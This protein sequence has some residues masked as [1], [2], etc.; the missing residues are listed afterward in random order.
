MPTVDKDL[1]EL[2]SPLKKTSPPSGQGGDDLKE[3]LSPL[4]SDVSPQPVPVS[5]DLAPLLAPLS[6]DTAPAPTPEPKQEM[7]ELLSPLRDPE[8][9][10]PAGND[11]PV[12]V[13]EP[14]APQPQPAPAAQA[15]VLAPQPA[16]PLRTIATPDGLVIG[17][18]NLKNF[19]LSNL[20]NADVAELT[21][22]IHDSNVNLLALQE[23]EG[24]AVMDAAMMPHF[25][26]WQYRMNDTPSQQ[27]LGFM[28]NPEMVD[29]R[30]DPLSYY[31]DEKLP[32]LDDT[33]LFSRPPMV[34]DFVDKKTGAPFRV[35]NVHLKSQFIPSGLSKEGR[36]EVKSRNDFLRQLQ[37]A[38]LN[39]LGNS[40]HADGT[41]V[42]IVGDYNQ[43]FL[44]NTPASK[45]A[46]KSLPGDLHHL[47]KGQKSFDKID[48]N[49]RNL[50]SN[51]DYLISMGMPFGSVGLPYEQE[52]ALARRQ[53]GTRESPDHDLV[54][55]VVRFAKN[56]GL[57][58]DVIKPD[59]SSTAVVNRDWDPGFRNNPYV[60]DA[61]QGERSAAEVFDDILPH[62]AGYKRNNSVTPYHNR[63][64][65]RDYAQSK[66]PAAIQELVYTPLA[67]LGHIARTGKD[68]PKPPFPEETKSGTGNAFTGFESGDLIP[69]ASS[70]MSNIA[71]TLAKGF[72][73][74]D[75]TASAI[76]KSLLETGIGK[77]PGMHKWTAY[78]PHTTPNPTIAWTP[79]E[80]QPMNVEDAEDLANWFSGPPPK[81]EAKDRNPEQELKDLLAL[82]PE[83]SGFNANPEFVPDSRG[84]LIK[85]E[86]VPEGDP[87]FKPLLPVL[88]DIAYST[89]GGFNDWLADTT[90]GLGVKL[91]GLTDWAGD[92][93]GLWNTDNTNFLQDSGRAIRN[94]ARLADREVG[95]KK[96]LTNQIARKFGGMIP[97]YAAMAAGGAGLLSP[98]S[99]PGTVVSYP[100]ATLGKQILSTVLGSGAQAMTAAGDVYKTTREL[101]GTHKQAMNAANKAELAS[102]AFNL[103]ANALAGPHGFFTAGRLS[104]NPLMQK[105]WRADRWIERPF[106][107]PIYYGAKLSGF[108]WPRSY[109]NFMQLG[110]A[111]ANSGLRSAAQQ[112]FQTENRRAAVQTSLPEQFRLAGATPEKTW[113]ES[114][115]KDSKPFDQKLR[116]EAIPAFYSGALAGL[117]SM[118]PQVFKNFYSGAKEDLRTY[119]T[120]RAQKQ[121]DLKRLGEEQ[122]TLRE[123]LSDAYASMAPESE[124]ESIRSRLRDNRQLQQQTESRSPA[125]DALFPYSSPVASAYNRWTFTPYKTR[126]EKI[127]DLKSQLKDLDSKLAIRELTPEE[128]QSYLSPQL[129]GRIVRGS[130]TDPHF[131][132][133]N[134]RGELGELLDQRDEVTARLDDLAH[135]V[136]TA[137]RDFDPTRLARNVARSQVNKFLDFWDLH[138][139]L[140]EGSKELRTLENSALQS[141]LQSNLHDPTDRQLDYTLE[142]YK[143]MPKSARSR[144]KTKYRDVQA[145]RAISKAYGAIRR[146]NAERDAA[147]D[148]LAYE[149]QSPYK[150]D[151]VIEANRRRQLKKRAAGDETP[152]LKSWVDAL[153]LANRIVDVPERSKLDEI[154]YALNQFN[155]ADLPLLASELD[156]YSRSHKRHISIINDPKS[157]PRQVA[158]SR[159]IFQRQAPI[160]DFVG[161]LMNKK[162][163]EQPFK[164]GGTDLWKLMRLANQQSDIERLIFGGR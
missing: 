147:R 11:E 82:D 61:M 1:E 51:L 38:R 58:P 124:I 145:D 48:K 123:K 128:R 98:L 154:D 73:Y 95:D 86:D 122:Q 43:N 131:V 62:H 87:N 119:Q 108:R 54:A 100:A 144:V 149:L 16:V 120:K 83:N 32:Q 45:A 85:T 55:S 52:M 109:I 132:P 14:V 113:L 111:L 18:N 25:N 143:S 67:W 162:A 79:S 104:Q 133:Y 93:T 106:L 142:Q 91:H 26:G 4:S 13:S 92:L 70:A 152:Q 59:E 155:K 19:N 46:R 74:S 66:T 49:G 136:R 60:L 20:T 56:N 84:T 31:A 102:L 97:T 28:W 35:V 2:L 112:M 69:L 103:G 3:L 63:Y 15:P 101:G 5:P 22:R 12:P 121:T 130:F 114:F 7:A 99:G 158:N 156:K 76:G 105:I 164:A 80:P 139:K 9:E 33:P 34:A 134:T 37:I 127:A 10:P 36:A 17:T 141:L 30:G 44:S 6:Q 94:L 118:G 41:P 29:L 96:S 40:L 24:N 157:T 64:A 8:S 150:A 163:A 137:L 57:L 53:L 65:Y 27:D 140:K 115:W 160:I 75:E 68:I 89:A 39:D 161:F 107:S 78:K 153:E 77:L 81:S 159:A 126:S 125:L 72:R 71:K 138:P 135:P 90:E 146:E 148:E 88:R 151:P 23:I 42:F 116:D 117:M 47:P 50:G 110:R 21:K 129:N